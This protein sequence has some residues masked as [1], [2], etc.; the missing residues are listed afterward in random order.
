MSV[1][2]WTYPELRFIVANQFKLSDTEL[3]VE[4][5]RRFHGGEAVRTMPEVEKVMRGKNILNK[6]KKDRGY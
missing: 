3:V 2:M 5:N 4:V 6:D 1:R